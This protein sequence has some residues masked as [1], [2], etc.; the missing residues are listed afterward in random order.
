[1]LPSMHPRDADPSLVTY[2]HVVYALHAASLIVGV[3]GSA[4]II[5]SFLLG[6]PS[7][8]AVVMN[9]VRK[10]DAAGTWLESH[11]RWQIRTFWYAVAAVCVAGAVCLPFVILFGLGVLMFAGC[12]AVIGLWVPYRIV[13]GWLALGNSQSLPQP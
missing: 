6:V 1:M 8:L 5:G 4:T 9:Y 7:I 11:F 13:R 2:T 10:A 3:V 12:A